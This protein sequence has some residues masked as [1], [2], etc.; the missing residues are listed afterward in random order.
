M[1]LCI[2]FFLIITFQVHA[3][4]T[5]ININNNN[6]NTSV[7][8]TQNREI[9]KSVSQLFA[10]VL[11]EVIVVKQQVMNTIKPLS[12]FTYYISFALVTLFLIYSIFQGS[13]A[14]D[15]LGL[16]V[17]R[18][19]IVY[20]IFSLNYDHNKNGLYGDVIEMGEYYISNIVPRPKFEKE[21]AEN[22]ERFSSSAFLVKVTDRTIEV[23]AIEL[24]DGI[25]Y[26]GGIVTGQ[27]D[28]NMREKLKDEGW[29]IRLAFWALQG[30][31]LIMDVS[32]LFIHIL[33][34]FIKITAILTF[35]LMI[36]MFTTRTLHRITNNFFIFLASWII[37]FPLVVFI[38]KQMVFGFSNTILSAGIGNYWKISKINE[39]VIIETITD[40]FI[41]TI[42][43]SITLIFSSFL[44]FASPLIT[45]SILR[46]NLLNVIAQASTSL[47]TMLA[48]L[49]S[50]SIIGA[51]GAKM[52]IEAERAKLEA[53]KQF[54]TQMAQIE[55]F[56]S[57]MQN[58]IRTQATV[59]TINAETFINIDKAIKELD[60]KQKQL[61]Q[62]L[63]I[64]MQ[65]NNLSLQNAI[66][67][68]QK[69]AQLESQRIQLQAIHTL[70]V[71]GQ[72]PNQD[73]NLTVA[74]QPFPASVVSDFV[75]KGYVGLVDSILDKS[76]EELKGMNTILDTIGGKINDQNI[77]SQISDIKNDLQNLERMTTAIGHHI[78]LIKN[79]ASQEGSINLA[80]GIS[81]TSLSKMLNEYNSATQAVNNKLG[82]LFSGNLPQSLGNIVFDKA[83]V[84]ILRNTVETKIQ[85]DALQAMATVNSDTLRNQTGV[86]VTAL[87]N[88]ANT[89]T[90]IETNKLANMLNLNQAV[91]HMKQD[92]INQ[93]FDSMLQANA[94][95]QT[96]SFIQ[97]LGSNVGYHLSQSASNFARY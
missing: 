45:I 90:D 36:A 86:Q 55:Q 21:F 26:I 92:A 5:N 1:I 4:N 70:P 42:V 51:F 84:D 32:N 24:E 62:N 68:I 59:D 41:F 25:R 71:L 40:P 23:P 73:Y 93:K 10:S 9:A 57:D 69:T 74:T 33:D 58:K 18:V 17:A 52:Q 72:I 38:V 82:L 11:Q 44:L 89:L 8:S 46:G 39:R 64:E 15:T 67:A 13:M 87:Q 37:L 81:M 16:L 20:F 50:Q 79:Q 77:Q 56:A 60:I 35:P 22:F 65:R 66:N 61:M 12:K 47:Y 30:S 96:A 91:M 19:A 53:D 48:S 49:A 76:K 34:L 2:L 94:M 14:K 7:Q 27:I 63:Q 85:N 31:K 54:N 83:N 75:I 95:Q 3:Q 43:A 29:R 80:G 6:S 28:A 88:R 78:N 97:Q